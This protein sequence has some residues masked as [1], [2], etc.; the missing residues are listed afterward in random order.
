[1]GITISRAIGKVVMSVDRPIVREDAV[2]G[3]ALV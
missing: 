3:V 2:A 1:L